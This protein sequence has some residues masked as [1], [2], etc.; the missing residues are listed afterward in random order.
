MDIETV[1]SQLK[2]LRL[3]VAAAE[4]ESVLSNHKKAVSLGW[5]GEL[6]ERE[7]DARKENALNARI[8]AAKFPE[9][10]TIEGFDFSFNPTI[11]EPAIR[12]LPSL[13]FIQQNRIALFLGN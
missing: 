4:I 2:A 10:T 1:R 12:R 6:L 9:A 13:G 3:G 8:K 7:L 5:L 11:D